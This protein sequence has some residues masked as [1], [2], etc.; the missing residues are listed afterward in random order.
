METN[1]KISVLD[2]IEG[3]KVLINNEPKQTQKSGEDSGESVN[4]YCQK[5]HKMELISKLLLIILHLI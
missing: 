4:Y 5:E 2:E 1:N 3:Q